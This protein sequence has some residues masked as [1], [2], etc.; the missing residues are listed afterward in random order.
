MK[1]LDQTERPKVLV[2]SSLN[3]SPESNLLLHVF[4]RINEGHLNFEL[5]N[6]SDLVD[7]KLT[8]ERYDNMWEIAIDVV[9]ERVFKADALIVFDDSLQIHAKNFTIDL[10]RK[11]A[12]T[13][14]L[15]GK[16]VCII[17]TREKDF[18]FT[19]LYTT[20]KAQKVTI[21]KKLMLFLPGLS[22]QFNGRREITVPATY[23]KIVCFNDALREML[24]IRY[25]MQLSG[26][27]HV[28]IARLNY[29]L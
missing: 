14:C 10:F 1:S 24:D 19:Q 17:N 25:E 8:K 15:T 7:T 6:T 26:N 3:T 12:E 11:L 23:T 18:A 5:L 20:L 16:T 29:A 22:K 4:K 2:F 21:N 27:S 9:S 28:N 13:R